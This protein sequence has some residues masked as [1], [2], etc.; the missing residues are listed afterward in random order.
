LQFQ[1]ASGY[2]PAAYSA[3][4]AAVGPVLQPDDVAAPIVFAAMQPPH[5]HISNLTIRNTRGE[6]P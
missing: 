4:M 5:T 2:D 1:A 6:Y 3:V